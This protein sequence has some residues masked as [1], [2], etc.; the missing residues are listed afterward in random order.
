[1]PTQ[2]SP[3][4]LKL[5]SSTKLVLLQAD[6]LD[7]HAA[8]LLSHTKVITDTSPTLRATSQLHYQSLD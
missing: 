3:D 8:D 7:L 1:M 4:V 2:A 5:V 6:A